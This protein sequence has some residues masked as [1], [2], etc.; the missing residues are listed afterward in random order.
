MDD[1]QV[2]RKIWRESKPHAPAALLAYLARNDLPFPATGLPAVAPG[3]KQIIAICGW[4]VERYG[5]EYLHFRCPA[6]RSSMYEPCT[7]RG[8]GHARHVARNHQ[9]ECCAQRAAM[10]QESIFPDSLGG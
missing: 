4:T 1:A 5:Y 8:M 6:C 9:P 7:A 3:L 10:N 2:A